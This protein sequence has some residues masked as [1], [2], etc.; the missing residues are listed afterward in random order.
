MAEPPARQRLYFFWDY[1]ITEDDLR[2]IL[3]GDDE[4]EKAWAITRLL[5]AARWDDIWR[6]ISLDD[7][8]AHFHRLRFR[9]SRDREMWAY[10]LKRW[11]DAAKAA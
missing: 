8:R 6:F 10:A 4:Y 5:E 2:A 7:L 1:D 9:F 11:T 3:Q